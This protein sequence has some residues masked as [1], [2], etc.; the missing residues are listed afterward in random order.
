M[1]VVCNVYANCMKVYVY[2]MKMY[3]ICMEVHEYGMKSV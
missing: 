2:G 1:K 3:E